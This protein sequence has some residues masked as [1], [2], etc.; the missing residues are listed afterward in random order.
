MTIARNVLIANWFV[1]FC[2]IISNKAHLQKANWVSASFYC[3]LLTNLATNNVI[4]VNND[5]SLVRYFKLY[6]LT[7]LLPLYK[8]NTA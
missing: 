1:D 7:N 6:R 8:G 4:K 5:N 2:K 3:N